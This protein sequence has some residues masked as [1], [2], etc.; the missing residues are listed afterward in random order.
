MPG[1]PARGEPGEMSQRASQAP[2]PVVSR[3]ELLQRVEGDMKLLQDLVEVFRE[4]L[5]GRLRALRDALER[6]DL[7]AVFA[8][9]HAIKGSVSTFAAAAAYEAASQ[10]EDLARSGKDDGLKAATDV[11]EREINRLQP[12]LREILKA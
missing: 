1:L 4:D 8:G 5:P 6:D 7:D 10:L 3:D 2:T 11:L 12:A 9:A